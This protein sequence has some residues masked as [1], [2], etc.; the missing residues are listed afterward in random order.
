MRLVARRATVRRWPVL[1]LAAIIAVLSVAITSTAQ[2]APNAGEAW[3]LNKSGQLGNG[4][5]AGPEKC[6]PEQV[7]CSTTPVAVSALS[8]ITA[9]S[10]GGSHSLALLENGT[11]MAWGEN[12]SGQLGD[13]TENDSNVPVAVSG[14]SEVVA[15]AA[16]S[17]HSLALLSDGTV[18]AWG[19]NGNGQLGNG[20]ETKSALPVAV[21]G[22]SGVKAIAAGER[23]SL[24]LLSDG[25][26]MA[27]GNNGNG[28][29]GNGSETGSNVPVAVSGLS[30][31]IAISAGSVHGLALLS[32]GTAMA[33]GDNSKG[34]LGNGNTTGS[35]VPVAVSGLSG[36]SA[37]S[38]GGRQNLALVGNGTVM[39]W[40]DN[41]DGQVGDGSS[42]GPEKCGE[43][44][45]LACAKTPVAVSKLSGV[46]AVDAGAQHSLAL[47]ASGAVMAWGRNARGQLGDG[48]STGPEA[49]GPFADPCSTTP[50]AAGTHGARVGISAGREHSL[51]FG[52]PPPS[53]NLP[54]LG[55]CVKV[56]TGGKYKYKNCVVPSAKGNG[57]YEWLPGPGEK[58]KFTVEIGEVELETVGKARVSCG[59]SELTGEWTGGKTAAVNL[60]F[61]GCLNTGTAKSCQSNPLQPAQITTSTFIEGEEIPMPIEG[62]LGYIKKPPMPQVGLDL[63]P[64]EG[65]SNVL[66]FSCG[67]S[68]G[69]EQPEPWTVEGSVIG[70]I[71]PLAV[72]GTAI[73]LNYKAV[74]GK[75]LPEFFEGQPKDTLIAKRTVGVEQK[76]EQAG[77]TFRA[78]PKVGTVLG[79]YE[80]PLEIKAK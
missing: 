4:S 8:G 65:S 27:W 25:T 49:C 43:P 41:G 63:K 18:M 1:C 13:G 61:Q 80:E 24:A 22:L 31:A 54:E 60:R 67:G 2:A 40:G 64:T 77:L 6:G 68:L 71:R 58:P 20:S 10:A 14:L 5:N 53:G 9:V 33:W 52:P 44:A 35:D 19:N 56:G 70:R 57:A 55:R 66:S 12:S 78:E 75:Q 79:E 51:A 47:L 23:F 29:L 46:S 72:M 69:G 76:T 32:N 62:E 26:V 16:G 3:G 21:S 42:T 39:A 30:G 74:G 48:T 34:Q 15:V 45:T 50:V 38:A 59:F 11:A 17:D 36:V 28:Q 73:K 37:I 7:A